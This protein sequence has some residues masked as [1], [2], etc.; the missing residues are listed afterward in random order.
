MATK[1]EEY[2]RQNPTVS[3]GYDESKHQLVGVHPNGNTFYIDKRVVSPEDAGVYSEKAMSHPYLN[4]GDTSGLGGFLKEVAMNTAAIPVDILTGTVE[5]V[6]KV[7][8]S[9]AKTITGTT[10]AAYE[11]G[12]S[13]ATL[14]VTGKQIGRAHV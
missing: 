6:N 10:P 8:G 2:Q 4:Y 3:V 5:Y 11:P 9:V 1:L 13:A 14:I 12:A 7:V